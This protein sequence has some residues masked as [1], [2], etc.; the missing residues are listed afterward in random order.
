MGRRYISPRD[1]ERDIL[2]YVPYS[3]MFEEFRAYRP[4]MNPEEDAELL[5]REERNLIIE[6]KF[7][8]P[9]YFPNTRLFEFLE[10]PMDVNA[11][12]RAIEAFR[13]YTTNSTVESGDKF[14]INAVTGPITQFSEETMYGKTYR[15]TANVGN[16]SFI[17]KELKDREEGTNRKELIHEA[18]IGTTL[19]SAREFTPI[20]SAVLGFAYCGSIDSRSP[21]WCRSSPSN[22]KVVCIYETV[23]GV[24]AEDVEL[25]EERIINLLLI[26]FT[27]LQRAHDSTGFTHGDLHGA[28]VLVE[29]L[30]TPVAVPI[31]NKFVVTDVIPHIIDYGMSCIDFEGILYSRKNLFWAA[32]V[33]NI[34]ADAYTFMNTLFYYNTS[35]RNHMDLGDYIYR[36]FGVENGMTRMTEEFR[37]RKR[38]YPNINL[39][40][41]NT[42]QSGKNIWGLIDHIA[43]RNPDLV[44]RESEVPEDV[45]FYKCDMRG[46]R[47]CVAPRDEIRKRIHHSRTLTEIIRFIDDFMKSSSPDRDPT[48]QEVR[49][50]N[51]M[52]STRNFHELISTLPLQRRLDVYENLIE[53]TRAMR[54]TETEEEMTQYFLATEDAL[55]IVRND[56]GVR[57]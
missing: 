16:Y 13:E 14:P 19:F 43:A 6:N 36:F 37:S 51:S 25:N 27:G 53:I 28:N 54:D 17:I 5:E 39:N 31:G 9:K 7:N 21:L 23:R 24:P 47:R 55:G 40:V 12:Q 49:V 38:I 42:I 41:V 20:F 44:Y 52:L 46:A 50:Y 1:V 4:R 56:E 57:S 35:A 34:F 3:R 26:L 2:V 8:P 11:L 29:V 15:T 32:R 45:P 18:F 22:E 30:Q 48:V 33:P 10:R